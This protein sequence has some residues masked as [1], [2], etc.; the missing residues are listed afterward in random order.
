MF[1]NMTVARKIGFGFGSVFCVL[2]VVAA[3]SGKDN[4]G[5]P[6]VLGTRWRRP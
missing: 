1:K 4:R 6:L 5:E 3:W 2:V